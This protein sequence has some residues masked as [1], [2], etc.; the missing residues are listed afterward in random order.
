MDFNLKF[1]WPELAVF[2]AAI[3]VL[4][5]DL[6]LGQ[7]RKII[8]SWVSLSGI[9]IAL[10]V[11]LYFSGQEGEIFNNSLI[12]DSLA[13]SA[14]LILLFSVSLIFLGLTT[15]RT[16]SRGRGEFLLLLLFSV[17]GALVM[18]SANDLIVLYLGIELTALPVYILVGFN[19]YDSRSM[20]ASIKYF[21]LGMIASIIMILGMSMLYGLSGSTQYGKIAIFLSENFDLTI[22]RLSMVLI[23]FGLLFKVAAFP[24]HF[25]APD[26]YEGAPTA[27]VTYLISGPKIAAF[28][29]LLRLYPLVYAALSEDWLLFFALISA[30][31]MTFGNIIALAQKNVKRM[32]AYSSIAHAGYLL[33]ALGVGTKFAYK[34]LLFYL[35]VYSLANIGIFLIILSIGRGK[36]DINIEDFNGLHKRNGLISL[37]MVLFLV[38]LIG[39]PPLGGFIGKL[40][41]FGAA[42]DGGM[43]WLALFGVLNSV[44]SLGY[45]IKIARSMY[46]K[47][48]KK[49]TLVLS[50]TLNISIII[51]IILILILG[52][53]PNSFL[54]F[55][56]L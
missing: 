25:W 42:I 33:I 14:K 36:E 6:F 3:S 13:D 51:S 12:F 16:L 34:S 19:K 26:T 35:F 53:Y 31:T 9:I 54:T 50:P 11:I 28:A 37:A 24:F 47:D 20:E 18:I 7:K 46:L 55:I 56:G 30:L 22:A 43:A 23:A 48:T 41:L 45:Y 52:I 40:Y 38:S 5:L 21:L 8:L 39:I 4:G 32:M 29:V 17:F 27:T 44:L 1:V 15:E 2:S 10:G 49:G